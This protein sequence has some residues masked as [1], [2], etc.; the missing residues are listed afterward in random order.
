ME[1]SELEALRKKRQ[2]LIDK[3][4]D[5]GFE[6]APK[7]EFFKAPGGQS[8]PLVITIREGGDSGTLVQYSSDMREEEPSQKSFDPKE[9]VHIATVKFSKSALETLVFYSDPYSQGSY[10]HVHLNIMNVEDIEVAAVEASR[11]RR[12]KRFLRK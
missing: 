5:L 10:F 11:K 3:I 8:I 4:K 2:L 1:V 9:V 12:L 6:S 7:G